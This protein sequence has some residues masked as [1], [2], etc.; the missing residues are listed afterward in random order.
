MHIPMVSSNTN[1]APSPYFLCSKIPEESHTLFT[2]DWYQSIPF[3]WLYLSE[4]WIFGCGSRS[5][6]PLVNIMTKLVELLG[7]SLT[8]YWLILIHSH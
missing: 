6:V 1:D 2:T 5:P 8:I 7:C 4:V 3:C